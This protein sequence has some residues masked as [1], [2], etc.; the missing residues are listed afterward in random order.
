MCL[1]L[2][3]C[4]TLPQD[5]DHETC[6]PIGEEAC[7]VTAPASCPDP[8]VTYGD[9]EPILVRDCVT[10]HDGTQ[11]IWP[12]NE[13]GHVAAWYDEIRTEMLECGMPPPDTCSAITPADREKILAWIR[14]GTPP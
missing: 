14:C 11:D 13:Y 8:A 2:I 3:A 4:G 1:V 7:T 6:T 9:I 12:L 10:C 5:D